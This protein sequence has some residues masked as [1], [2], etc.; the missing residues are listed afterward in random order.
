MKK[1]ALAFLIVACSPA[2]QPAA[3]D[4]PATA[5]APIFELG[6]ITVLEAGTPMLK[7]HANGTTEIAAHHGAMTVAPGAPASSA[8]L[9]VE[10]QP[11]PTFAADGSLTNNGQPIARLAADGTLHAKDRALPIV[12][13]AD[14]VTLSQLAAAISIDANGQIHFEG[15]N[16]QAVPKD[17]R[18]QGANTPGQRRA[19][20]TL[21]ALLLMPPE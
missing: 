4:R 1:L 6:E 14:R 2:A 11:G 18:V 16:S 9:P 17:L 5:A 12:V 19:V 15:G 3:V 13:T 7:L 21:L 10:L 20:L 8:S